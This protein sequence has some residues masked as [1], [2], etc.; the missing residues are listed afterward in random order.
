MCGHTKIF[1]SS[2][3][4]VGKNE[5]KIG[6]MENAASVEIRKKGGL[7]PP[8]GKVVRQSLHDFPTFPTGFNGFALFQKLKETGYRRERGKMK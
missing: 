4:F 3:E 2:A 6:L 1:G 5:K 8:L 7:P